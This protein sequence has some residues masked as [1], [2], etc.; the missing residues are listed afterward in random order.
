LSGLII[1]MLLAISA[2][3]RGQEAEERYLQIFNIIERAD[4]LVESGQTNLARARYQEAQN[5][6]LTLKRS[7]PA[8]NVKAVS[9]RLNYVAAKIAAL[10]KPAAAPEPSD[11][12]TSAP[13]S[14]SQ[15]R[16]AAAPG[17]GQ[18]KL[19]DAGAEPRRVLRLQAKAGEKQTTEMTVRMAMTMGVGDGQ[20]MK[21]P[22]MKMLMGAVPKSIS[23]EGDITCEVIIEDATV[24]DEPGAMPQMVEAMKASLRGINGLVVTRTISSRGFSKKTEITTATGSGSGTQQTLEQMKESF[25]NSEFFLPEEAVGTGAKWEVR[26][27]IKT[28]GMTV[29]QTT[30]FQLA[31]MEG[32]ILTIKTSATKSAANQKMVNPA[33]PQLNVD[34]TKMTGSGASSM[35][36]DLAKVL[37]SQATIDDHSDM[38]MA[39]NVGGQKQTMNMKADMNIRME[40][41]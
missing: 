8:W 29:D 28:Q 3:V 5:A 11:A 15:T 41:K 4:S 19:L 1:V 2:P 24:A 30:T 36:I 40:T 16:P 12:A 20:V 10:S 26:Q 22:P 13:R 27:K 31:S 9:Y 21:M 39:M 35:T 38:T 25:S 23:E 32:D 34:L 17:G 18:V 37:A 7:N 33:M 14:D 6:L